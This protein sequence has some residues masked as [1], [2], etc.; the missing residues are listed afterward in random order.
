M[1]IPDDAN[2]AFRNIL[3]MI[4]SLVIIF[5]TAW[6]LHIIHAKIFSILL[7]CL[8]LY[9]LTYFIIN[10][11]IRATADNSTFQILGKKLLYIVSIILCIGI[12][13]ELITI[14]IPTII[15]SKDINS[16]NLLS[17]TKIPVYCDDIITI[18]KWENTP[19][20]VIDI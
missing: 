16:D 14:P 9:I 20:Y 19:W 18:G 5:I 8:F 6:F 11:Y 1:I 17:S 3:G 2:I 7:G 4:L 10:R 15:R 13:Y 12:L